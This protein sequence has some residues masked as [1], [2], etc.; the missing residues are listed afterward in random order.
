MN[1]VTL[2]DHGGFDPRKKSVKS[3]SE[4]KNALTRF[5]GLW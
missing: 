1:V 4:P 5:V 2:E 3:M